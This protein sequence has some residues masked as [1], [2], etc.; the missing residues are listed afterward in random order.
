MID[1]AR[2]SYCCSMTA[3]QAYERSFKVIYGGDLCGADYPE[4]LDYELMVM[5]KGFAKVMS[6]KEI[7]KSI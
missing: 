2:A 1:D 6:L 3:R 5:R 4:L 7:I